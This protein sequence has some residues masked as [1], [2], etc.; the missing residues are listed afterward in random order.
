M[1]TKVLSRPRTD[2][3]RELLAA[4]NARWLGSYAGE[5][6]YLNKQDRMERWLV[7]KTVVVVHYFDDSVYF[8]SPDYAS[9]FAGHGDQ[10]TWEATALW[11]AKIKA[12]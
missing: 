11:L 8:F 9:E 3:A 4:V 1:A 7:G 6:N 12:A 10:S 5:P 2:K